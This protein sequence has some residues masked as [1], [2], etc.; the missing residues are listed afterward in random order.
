MPALGAERARIVDQIAEDL[1][2]RSF[3]SKHEQT[4]W[5]RPSE[6]DLDV[7]A[8]IFRRLIGVREFVEQR[9]EI[10]AA[11][12]AACGF[13]FDAGRAGNIGDE[14]IKALHVLRYDA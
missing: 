13:R 1:A 2:E 14:A 7:A 9:A 8:R 3:L 10:D 6:D 5:L 12:I 4:L 11:E